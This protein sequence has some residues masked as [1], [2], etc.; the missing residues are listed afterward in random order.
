[1]SAPVSLFAAIGRG[2]KGRCPACGTGKLFHAYLKVADHCPSCQEDFTHQRADDMPAW[3]NILIVGHIVLPTMMWVEYSYE[4]PI[5][6]HMLLW[7]PICLGLSISLLQPIKGGIV[8]LQWSMGL[9]GFAP[10]RK[11]RL[12]QSRDSATPRD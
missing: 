12:E 10:A 11:Q 4:P 1:M 7:I 3:L 9:H 6:V 2:I 8:G 5:W